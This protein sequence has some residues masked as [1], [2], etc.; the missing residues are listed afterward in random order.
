[1]IYGSRGSIGLLSRDG[2]RKCG[3]KLG[4]NELYKGIHTLIGFFCLDFYENNVYYI[5]KQEIQEEI[6]NETKD[7]KRS[8]S[9]KLISYG[10][11]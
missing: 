7:G 2:F 3:G 6:Y 1:M 4:N 10:D 8:R 5:E 9:A 11:E